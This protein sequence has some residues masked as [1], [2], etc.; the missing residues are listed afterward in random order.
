MRAEF[1]VSIVVAAL[2]H[3]VDIEFGED[4]GKSV[5]IVEFKGFAVMG[6][7]LNFVTG[8]RGSVRLA[9][10]PQDFEETFGAE[11]NGVSN[12]NRRKRSIFVR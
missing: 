7:T 10:G 12:F 4:A 11:L 1:F 3:E 6:A 9:R 2:A 5:G 8:R